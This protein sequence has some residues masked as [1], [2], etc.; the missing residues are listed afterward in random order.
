MKRFVSVLMVLT[1]VAGCMVPA[2]ALA[3][4]KAQADIAL[5]LDEL[6][7]PGLE[8]SPDMLEAVRGLLDMLRLECSYEMDAKLGMLTQFR[9]LCKERPV[10][11]LQIA[12]M[13]DGVAISGDLLPEG[14]W[15]IS[16]AQMESYSPGAGEAMKTLYQQTVVSDEQLRMHIL[17]DGNPRSL[18]VSVADD[19]GKAFAAWAAENAASITPESG[20]SG[21][22]YGFTLMPEQV[23]ALLNGQLDCI[24]S[25]EMA[26]EIEAANT[27]IGQ[28]GELDMAEVM[29]MAKEGVAELFDD[30]M[31]RDVFTGEVHINE[32]GVL[33]DVRAYAF[34]GPYQEG[35]MKLNY[36]YIA[37][38]SFK[39]YLVNFVAQSMLDPGRITASLETTLYKPEMS[40]VRTT[41][42]LEFMSSMWGTVNVQSSMDARE[43]PIGPEDT[44]Q[45]FFQ[46]NIDVSPLNDP[47]INILVDYMVRSN[48][49]GPIDPLH[50]DLTQILTL[51]AMRNGWE[52]TAFNIQARMILGSRSEL[53]DV[54]PQIPT[55]AQG[56]DLLALSEQEMAEFGELTML[57]VEQVGMAILSQLPP[58]QYRAL[59]G[60]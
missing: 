19:C 56:K 53:A 39:T 32:R 31:F 21:T 8:M 30:R 6:R 2:T 1:L 28:A 60:N 44:D 13:A 48:L 46:M 41:S 12:Y 17:R 27:Q 38:D 20:A 16:Y 7:I 47:A 45:T 54:Q 18:A 4:Q 52:R 33:E 5:S 35:A 43:Q 23:L 24:A 57:R 22:Y 59:T 58:D 3:G 14:W 49:P 29:R 26:K 11:E 55:P 34:F 50:Q 25:S 9:L 36:E 37:S 40:R 51:G 42:E 10:A 15:H